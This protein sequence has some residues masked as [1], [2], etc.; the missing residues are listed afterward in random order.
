VLEGVRGWVAGQ[1]VARFD[2]GDHVGHVLDT[3]DAQTVA[4]GPSL[5]FQ[6]VRDME[7]GHEA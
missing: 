5:T 7:P 3:I 2:A 6:M 4:A 1:V